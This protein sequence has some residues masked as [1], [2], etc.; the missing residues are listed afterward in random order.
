MPLNSSNVRWTFS[1]V[2]DLFVADALFDLFA[3]FFS[4]F[5][6]IFLDFSSL[7][8]EGHDFVNFLHSCNFCCSATSGCL[9]CPTSSSLL[10][11]LH[12][13]CC[14]W[15][16]LL[17]YPS[18]CSWLLHHPFLCLRLRLLRCVL[19]RAHWLLWVRFWPACMMLLCI[20]FLHDF[21][22]SALRIW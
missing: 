8:D 17:H 14:L 9:P 7:N 22:G 3:H 12:S 19:Q 21:S 15:L 20:N 1:C 16:R 2:L 13:S 10:L 5:F 4:S 6:V 18:A 11:L